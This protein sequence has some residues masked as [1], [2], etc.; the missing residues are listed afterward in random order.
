MTTSG[1][2]PD[3]LASAIDEALRPLVGAAS[4]PGLSWGLDVAGERLVGALGHLDAEGTVP[5]RTDSIF[6]ISSMT[7]TVTAVATLALVEEGQLSLDHPVDKL[8]RELADPTVLVRP[9]GP[10]DQ[11]EPAHRP[12]T[13]E[14]LLTFRLGHGT[15]FATMGDPAPLDERLA[16]LGLSLGP[17]APQDHPHP[18]VWLDLLGHLPLR[19]QPGRRWLYNTGAEVLGVLL[20]RACGCSL[21]EVLRERV[22]D[23]LGMTDTGFS[24]PTESLPRLG[25]CFTDRDPETGQVGVYDPPDGQWSRPP[26]F[27][28]GDGGLV[29]TIEDYLAFAVT[30]RGGRVLDGARL[31]SPDTV[32]AMTSNQL[33][34]EQTRANGLSPDGSTGWGYGVG[35]ALDRPSASTSASPSDST[36]AS[37]TARTVGSYGWDGGL[38]STWRNDTARGLSAVLLTNQMW[39]SP[40]SPVAAEAFWSVLAAEVPVSRGGRAP[41]APPHADS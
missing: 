10:L 15:D 39:S 33:T 19:H 7:K 9:D 36:S 13:V 20:A 22:L 41:S 17:P 28:G 23:P 16:E 14:D 5:A 21:G 1:L 29:S 34:E 26:A 27:E 2:D 4:P 32:G 12:I 11:V 37:A 31:L 25:A 30:L 18:D 3:H 8:L 40:E 6:R 35:I 24:V 38:G